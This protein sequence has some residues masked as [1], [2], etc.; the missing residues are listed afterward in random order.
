M[1]Q[2]LTDIHHHLLYDMDDGAHSAREMHA[3]LRRAKEEGIARIIATPHVTPG[4]EPFNQEQYDRALKEARAY[5][6]EKN[7]GI[8][9]YPGAEI[10]YTDQTCHFLEDGR[11][12][13][14]AGTEHVLV[15]FSPDIKYARLH[16]A[17]AELLHYGYLPIVA[18]VERYYCLLKHPSRLLE[19][20]KELDICYQVNCAT[21]IKRGGLF[22]KLFMKKILEWD[23]LDV[24]ATDAHHASSP[25]AANM[26]EAWRILKSEYGGAY[27][28]ELTD[29]HLLF[30]T[31]KSRKRS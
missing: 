31:A 30:E 17:L 9:I 29:G 1:R 28:N 22:T 21:I 2:G 16:D 19:L 10:L 3:M 5:S 8:E 25:R 26:R 11:V 4:V 13:T 27:A 18:H 20:K 12:P 7:L 6:A 15:E 14:L 23:L 24:I